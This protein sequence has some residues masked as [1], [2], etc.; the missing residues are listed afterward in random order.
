MKNEKK[1]KKLLNI[2]GAYVD[3][4][5]TLNLVKDAA[6]K[7]DEIFEEFLKDAVQKSER[8]HLKLRRFA[9]ENV[10]NPL[11]KKKIVESEIRNCQITVEVINNG[12]IKITMPIILPF[13]KTKAVKI[14]P[15][16]TNQSEIVEAF[17]RTNM[18]VNLLE[19][20]LLNFKNENKISTVP[21][22]NSTIY[23]KNIF[24]KKDIRSAF[25][26]DNYEYKQIT[27]AI[28]RTFANGNDSFDNL[29]FVLT[30]CVGSTTRTEIYLIPNQNLVA[31]LDAYCSANEG[32][33]KAEIINFP[34]NKN[35]VA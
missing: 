22:K 20:V 24:A 13:A 9:A 19:R 15:N 23:Y 31:S 6:V 35:Y 32:T 5:E 1:L 7:D 2:N 33:Q 16:E 27:D 25:D 14:Y 18:I 29:D 8:C 30:S 10:D 11:T 12:I 17:D 4:V 28:I 26:T 34:S 21:F 3:V